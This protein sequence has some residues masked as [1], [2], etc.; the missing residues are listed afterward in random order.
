VVEGRLAEGAEGEGK[1]GEFGC[2]NWGDMWV[3]GGDVLGLVGGLV[4]G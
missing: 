3:G 4:G 1:R 2:H